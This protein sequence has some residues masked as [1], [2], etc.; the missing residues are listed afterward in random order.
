MTI[1][2][3]RSPY[4]ARAPNAFDRFVIDVTR[5]L[6]A[7]WLGLRLAMLLRRLVMTRLGENGIDTSLW[8]ARLR[9]Y[10]KRNGCEKNALF[11]PQMLE[12]IERSA[13]SEAIARTHAHGRAFTFIDIGANVGLYSIFVGSRAKAGDKIL[14][15]EPQPSIVD[16]LAFNVGLNQDMPI[17]IIRCAIADKEGH[18]RFVL[19]P[20]DAGG[21]HL[22]EAG[23]EEWESVSVECIPLLPL[24][25]RHGVHAIDALKIDVEGAEHLALVPFFTAAPEKTWPDWLLIEDSQS[26]WPIDLFDFI[27]ARGYTQSARS[28]Q[29]LIFKRAADRI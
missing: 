7:N 6:P 28:K 17:D 15:I 18:M 22:E 16:R 13:L 2:V 1:L 4:G 29:N 11:T 20:R 9:L 3:D 27:R 14:A 10:P 8:G 23:A 24:L 21:A 12:P 25:E 19:H 5:T 26:L